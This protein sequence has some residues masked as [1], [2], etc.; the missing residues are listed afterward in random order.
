MDDREFSQD[1][2]CVAAP[3]RCDGVSVC[4]AI[5]LSSP[6]PDVC[7]L[8]LEKRLAMLREAANRIE[9]GLGRAR[10][11]SAQSRAVTG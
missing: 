3:V 4:A 9:A 8:T 10:V 1:L 7:R 6:L 5:S 2:I 11:G